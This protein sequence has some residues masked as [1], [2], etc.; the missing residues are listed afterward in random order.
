VPPGLRQRECH[1][2]SASR[3][4]AGNLPG[5]AEYVELAGEA[6]RSWPARRGRTRVG[7]EHDRPPARVVG[8]RHA[9]VGGQQ[10]DRPLAVQLAL[11]FKARTVA[12]HRH[13]RPLRSIGLVGLTEQ[14]ERL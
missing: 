7:A 1:G 2:V 13:R 3:S 10:R 11:A 6:A 4:I 5:A 12:E 9:I 14:D 8:Q